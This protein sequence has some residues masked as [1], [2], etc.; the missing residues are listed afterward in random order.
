MKLSREGKFSSVVGKVK[1]SL[2]EFDFKTCLG[3]VKTYLTTPFSELYADEFEDDEDFSFLEE[4]TMPES[5]IGIYHLEAKMVEDYKL[6]IPA[7]E[8]GYVVIASMSN[9]SKEDKNQFLLKLRTEL[10]KKALPHYP[11]NDE[12]IIVAEPS[13]AVIDFEEKKQQQ[14]KILYLANYRKK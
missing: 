9:L 4:D 11:V 12:C 6:V 1:K 14:G 3:K 8:A 2:S 5:N 13:V 7:I 10:F